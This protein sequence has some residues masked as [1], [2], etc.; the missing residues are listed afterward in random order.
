MEENW[1]KVEGSFKFEFVR[2]DQKNF[3]LLKNVATSSKNHAYSLTK[4][5]K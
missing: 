1:S 3:C 5:F 4:S 2:D